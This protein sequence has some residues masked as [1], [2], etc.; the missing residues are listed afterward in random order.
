M[1]KA[2]FA[3]L[4]ADIITEIGVS[5]LKVGNDVSMNFVILSSFFA[6][7]MPFVEILPITMPFLITGN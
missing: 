1:I 2:A 4:S 3:Y 6:P 7:N 5:G